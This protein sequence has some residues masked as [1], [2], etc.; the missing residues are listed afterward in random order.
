MTYN[1]FGGT[2]NLAQLN[3]TLLPRYLIMRVRCI[4]KHTCASAAVESHV[5]SSFSSHFLAL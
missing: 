4:K 5:S 1:V 2:L 3:S